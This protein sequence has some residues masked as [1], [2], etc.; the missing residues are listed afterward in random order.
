MNIPSNKRG[1][2]LEDFR[3]F[4]LSDPPSGRIDHHYHEFHKILL[5]CSG[6]GNYSIEG[7]RYPIFSGD[8]VLVGSRCVHRPEFDSAYERIILYISPEFLARSA[9]GD[10]DLNQLFN[11]EGPVLRLPETPRLKLFSLV[12]ALEQELSGGDYGS[13]ILAT[14]LLLRFL[15][16]LGRIRLGGN[17]LPSAAAAPYSSRTLEIMEY[18]HDHLSEELRIDHIANAFYISKYHMMRSFR[19]ETGMTLHTYITERRLLTAKDLIT[20][21]VNATDACFHAGFRSY[22]SFTRAY[23]ARFGCTPTGRRAPEARAEESYE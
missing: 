16:E 3:L 15:V 13:G 1:Y 20:Q 6:S 23:G 7:E 19:Q 14:G 10:C 9:T 2:L 18:I 21:G 8:T 4:H 11:T 22:C 17:T 12:T 5:L